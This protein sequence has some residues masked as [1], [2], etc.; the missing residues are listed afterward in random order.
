MA[1]PVSISA[2]ALAPGAPCG[3]ASGLLPAIGGAPAAG[4]GPGTLSRLAPS[5]R[6]SAG[7]AP[8]RSLLATLAGATPGPNPG[9]GPLPT[10]R[11]SCS[12]AAACSGDSAGR[13]VCERASETLHRPGCWLWGL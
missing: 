11:T 8:L 9:R 7:S 1:A 12:Q 2:S 6:S 5:S 3:G 4:S 10:P 13:K